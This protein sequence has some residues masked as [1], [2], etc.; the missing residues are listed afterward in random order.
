MNDNNN[1]KVTI[2]TFTLSFLPLELHQ[3]GA[4][5][6]AMHVTEGEASYIYIQTLC[7]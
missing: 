3:Q 2:A 4:V 1:N 5:L 7:Q 6:N